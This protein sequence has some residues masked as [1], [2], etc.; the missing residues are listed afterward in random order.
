MKLQSLKL[1]GAEEN[2]RGELGTQQGSRCV[3]D[4][5]HLGESTGSTGQVWSTNFGTQP[6]TMRVSCPVL[7]NKSQGPPVLL[8]RRE[9]LLLLSLKALPIGGLGVGLSKAMLRVLRV[10]RIN[11]TT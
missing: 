1:K 10:L 11:I 6:L 3:A 2:R 9:V 5:E 7:S 4:R 8:T